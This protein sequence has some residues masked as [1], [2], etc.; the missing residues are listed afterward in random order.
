M[1]IRQEQMDTFRE[2]ALRAF[3]DRTYIHLLDYFPHHCALLGEEQMRRAIQHGW[4]KAEGYDLTAECCVRSYI[5]F[6]CLLGSGF[7]TD[8]LLPWAAEILNDRS[9][10]DQVA[11]GDRLYD[12]AWVYI[13]HIIPDYRDAAGQPTTARFV[14]E[15]RK[16]RA[17][18]DDPL[19]PESNPRFFRSVMRWI[20][21]VFPAKYGYVGAEA[22][23]RLI[24]AGIEVAGGYGMVGERSI[25]IVV[26]LMFVLGRSFDHDPLIPW[27]SV[28]LNDQDIPNHKRGDRLFAEGVSFLRRW[29]DSVPGQES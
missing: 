4:Q 26:M 24:P 6:M 8:P 22:V 5:D 7:D 29:W 15:L 23:R 25:T 18:P 17:M 9:S 11:R 12:R 3:E 2:T 19:T 13:N 10:A 14:G 16:L 27:A 21:A 20:E 1:L 28:A